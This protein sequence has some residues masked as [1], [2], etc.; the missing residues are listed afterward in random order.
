MTL[1]DSQRDPLSDKSL[2]KRGDDLV[3]VDVAMIMSLDDISAKLTALTQATTRLLRLTQSQI[4]TGFFSMT[5]VVGTELTTL[6]PSTPWIGMAL[7]NDGPG[8][9]KMRIN[10]MRGDINT[11]LT[12]ASGDG[13]AWDSRYPT[14]NKLYFI[15][16][17]G[18]TASIKISGAEGKWR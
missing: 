5:L 12:V 14:I 3:P 13:W 11:E 2:I 17:S 15:V 7:E 6:V 1:K 9:I 16:S 18:T 8:D 10:R 4:T